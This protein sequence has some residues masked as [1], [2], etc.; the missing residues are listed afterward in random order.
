MF[1]PYFFVDCRIFEYFVKNVFCIWPMY[2]FWLL[3]G[4]LLPFLPLLCCVI[5]HHFLA[6]VLSSAIFYF[7]VYQL[8]Y[9]FS[10]LSL[11]RFYL[12]SFP[13][14]LFFVFLFNT[15]FLERLTSFFLFYLLSVAHIHL[16]S[17]SIHMILLVYFWYLY[18]YFCE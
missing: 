11:R 15:T 1:S 17:H 7:V 8:M 14:N 13:S 9:T 18:S 12:F 6:C 10:L 3:I 4:F 2:S 16:M 5:R